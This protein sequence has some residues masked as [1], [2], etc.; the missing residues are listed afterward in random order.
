MVKLGSTYT[1]SATQ[2]ATEP[3][4]STSN[5]P[6][7]P[8]ANLPIPTSFSVTVAKE[9][10]KFN[11]AH[12]VAYPGFRERLHGHNYTLSITLLSPNPMLQSDGYVVDFGVVKKSVRAVCKSLNERVI[13]PTNSDVI[14]IYSTTE[15]E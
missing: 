4:D 3:M 15:N 1:H 10:F 11:L 9:D 14:S 7:P 5:P 8:T 2:T 13:I 6:P 12:F